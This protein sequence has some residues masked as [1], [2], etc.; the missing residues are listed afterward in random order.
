MLMP[1]AP[2]KINLQEKFSKFTEHWSPKIIGELHGVAL[3]AVKL[4]GEFHWHHH[5]NE[6]ELCGV[7]KGHLTIH[8]KDK[9]VELNPGEILIIPKKIE[10]K[11][12]A[13]EEV[14]IVLIEP[15][16]TLNTGNVRSNKTVE[17]PEEI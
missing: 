15:K 8:F 1:P 13:P 2:K 16:E 14:E 9:D 11:P 4:K 17:T 7:T 5:E 6:D 10:H 12:E 3:K